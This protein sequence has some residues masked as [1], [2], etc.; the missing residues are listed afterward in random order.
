MPASDKK[1]PDPFSKSQV[2]R[3]LQA[4]LDIGKELT[5]LSESQLAKIPLPDNILEA[6]QFSHSLKSNGAKKRHLQ[7]LGKIIREVDPEPIK[8]ALQKIKFAL[9]ENT[10]QFHKLEQWRDDLI[11]TGDAALQ[12]LLELYPDADRQHLRQLIRNAKNDRDKNKNSGAETELFK[13]LR[14]LFT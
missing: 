11:V 13:Y 12:K 3:D 5:A 10:R 8:A 7:Y 14:T 2:K 4:L 1:L 9:K 6:V